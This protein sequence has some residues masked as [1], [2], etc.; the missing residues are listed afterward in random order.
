MMIKGGMGGEEGPEDEEKDE[1]IEELEGELWEDKKVL[2]GEVI[3]SWF[4]II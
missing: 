3:A 4:L 2:T 1:H